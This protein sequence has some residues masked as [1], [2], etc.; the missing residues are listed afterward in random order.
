[1]KFK[2]RIFCLIAFIAG[3]SNVLFSQSIT[4]KVIDKISGKG[5]AK[6]NISVLNTPFVSVSDSTGLFTLK[7]VKKGKYYFVFEAEEYSTVVQP[8]EVKDSINTLEV[9]LTSSLYSLNEV[10]V[11]ANK[12]DEDILKNKSS[13]SVLSAKKIEQL[14]IWDMSN[15][16]GVIPNYQYGNLGVGYQQQIALRGISVFSENPAV[17]TYVDGVCASDIS[18]NGMQLFDVDR[19]EVLR[20]PQGTQYGRNAIGGVINI[21]TNEPKNKTE[22]MLQSSIGN[23]GLQRYGFAFKTP[24]KR[25]KLFLGITGN[26][27][28][29]F[30]FYTNDLSDQFTF[31][32]QPLKG[33]PEDGKRLG[34]EES[35]YANLFLKWYI[36][37]KLKLTLNS[38]IQN[39]KSVGASAY[40]LAAPNDSIAFV[41]P[42]TINV[43][44]LGK[45]ERTLFNNSISLN[46]YG[47]RFN[48]ISILYH[49]LVLQSYDRID[50]DVSS[51][52]YAYGASF[53]NKT[54]EGVPQ[55]IINYEL[56]FSS[57]PNV[58]KYKW[59]LGTNLFY[60]HY[61]KQF[62]SVYQ[63]LALLFG[64]QPGT[65]VNRSLLINKS[66]ALFGQFE[67]FISKK[68]TATAGLRY[69]L[70]MRHASVSKF[71]VN[72]D[73][74]RIY[75]LPESSMQKMYNAI[76]PK[77]I[78]NYQFNDKQLLYISYTRGYRVGGMNMFTSN[79]NYRFYNPEFSDNGELGYKLRTKN[80]KFVLSATLFAYHWKDLQLD[81]QPEPGIWVVQNI[82]NVNSIGSEIEINA[83]PLPG[84]QLNG[85]Y[86]INNARYGDFNYLGTNIK[87]NQTI[88]AP[89]STVF[90]SATQLIP[91]KKKKAINLHFDWRRIGLQYFDLV[92]SI[93]QK[94]YNLFN[95]KVDF[96][97]HS[98]NLAIWCQNLFDEKYITYAMP[99]YFKYTLINRPRTF[100]LTLSY[101]L[102]K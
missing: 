85:G 4:G 38:K 57:K 25:N 26:Y 95:A 86:G 5:I 18:A 24:L 79:E 51:L 22:A 20:G 3:F 54:G 83:M 53:R 32:Q 88:F 52:D 41:K 34:D 1:M 99:G 74:T 23:Q 71:R 40:Y 62:A 10:V 9:L 93:E 61:D 82:G 67:Y 29:Q 90:L 65:E 16:T 92:N 43:N 33:T 56:R 78:L 15:L 59:I 28:K 63:Q 35:Y 21:I 76:S 73:D 69:D 91:F 2:S 44:V 42:Y 7:Q 84:L 64:T 13:V 48:A 97:F 12:E 102:K 100:G 80:K 37:T 49:Q 50:L 36:N 17:V 75:T 96:T 19:I 31:L 6:V 72:P 27:A 58:T 47:S 30:G 89:K 55:N 81:V 8:Y 70:E 87:G 46:Y 94:P 14:R 68:I 66:I 11:T 98:F 60:Q 45:N 39:D 77:L 101:I